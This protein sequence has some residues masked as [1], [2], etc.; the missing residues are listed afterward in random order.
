MK[1]DM[2]DKQLKLR[3]VEN[4]RLVGKLH[5]MHISIPKPDL[6]RD[7]L[8]R[9]QAEEISLRREELRHLSEQ[10]SREKKKESSKQAEQSSRANKSYTST[11]VEH[12][13]HTRPTDVPHMSHTRPTHGPHTAHTRP[14]HGPHKSHTCRCASLPHTMTLS[15]HTLPPLSHH[16]LI[17][18]AFIEMCSRF[19]EMCSRCVSPLLSFPHSCSCGRGIQ[20]SRGKRPSSSSK[21][22]GSTRRRVRQRERGRGRLLRAPRG[23]LKRTR[24]QRTQ[25]K[26]VRRKLTRRKLTRRKLTRHELVRRELTRRKVVDSRSSSHRRWCVRRRQR[27]GRRKPRPESTS[28]R[29]RLRD[30]QSSTTSRCYNVVRCVLLVS[31]TRHPFLPYAR[32]HSSHISP[33]HSSSSHISPLNSF[34]GAAGAAADAARE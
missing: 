3:S 25:R 14:T 19:I 1:L 28:S 20:S 18:R 26:L 24:T 33:L 15:Y 31:L 29:W 10:A 32:A 8:E 23:R 30:C 2:L 21:Q 12:T 4:E 22:E 34:S 5:E 17:A 9:D 13:S 6:I 16:S 11:Q 7:A 27:R